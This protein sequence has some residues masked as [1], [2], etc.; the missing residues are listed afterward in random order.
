MK[1]LIKPIGIRSHLVAGFF[2]VLAGIAV[3][4][5]AQNPKLIAYWDFD[6]PGN[7]VVDKVAGIRGEV[8]GTT[9]FVKG[10]SGNAVDFGQGRRGNWIRIYDNNNRWLKVHQQGNVMHKPMLLGEVGIFIGTQPAA[11]E[12]EIPG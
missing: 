12:V 7:V 8:K 5:Q 3:T 11:A 9:K 6:K 2:Y 1:Q 4:I 10:R